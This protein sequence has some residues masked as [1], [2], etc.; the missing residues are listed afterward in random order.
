MHD[1]PKTFYAHAGPPRCTVLLL[2]CDPA[3]SGRLA[4]AASSLG[5]SFTACSDLQDCRS[6]LASAEVAGVIAD[7]TWLRANPT[8][9]DQIAAAGPGV[10]LLVTC[11]QTPPLPQASSDSLACCRFLPL[12]E[13]EVTLIETLGDA[14]DKAR[15]QATNQRLVDGFYRRLAQLSPEESSILQA[16]CEG[17]LNKQIAREFGVSIRTVEQRRRR[18]FAKM[19]VGSAVPLA[20]QL[21]TVQTIVRLCPHIAPQGHAMPASMPQPI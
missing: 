15:L 18:M 6:H 8:A 2:G 20:S 19:E 7:P 5:A 17:K 21:A 12:C 16:V 4:A 14:L 9:T 11:E 10:I 13:S 3:V 1:S